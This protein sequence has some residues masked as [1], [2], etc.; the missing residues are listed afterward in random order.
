MFFLP[1]VEHLDVLKVEQ[2]SH[3]DIGT[4]KQQDKLVSGGLVGFD[5]DAFETGNNVPDVG[6]QRRVQ[7]WHRLQLRIHF[8]RFLHK[9]MPETKHRL[10]RK[11]NCDHEV[12]VENENNKNLVDIPTLG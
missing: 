7:V 10:V 8:D 3:G 2:A 6:Q 4:R 9:L 12:F 1:D 11:G 5:V